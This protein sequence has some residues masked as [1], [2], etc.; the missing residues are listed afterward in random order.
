MALGFKAKHAGFTIR[1]L[2]TLCPDALRKHLCYLLLVQSSLFS[3]HVILASLCLWGH[4]TSGP[5]SCEKCVASLLSW[6]LWSFSLCHGAWQSSRWWFLCQP[7]QAWEQ[8]EPH[9]AL[10]GHSL[11]VRLPLFRHWCVVSVCNLG[12]PD[13]CH[14]CW[15]NTLAN[16]LDT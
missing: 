9:P 8:T 1:F 12:H 3:R 4:V 16:K 2:T 14:L 13:W 11:S 6:V 5:S 7:G 10:G 15:P